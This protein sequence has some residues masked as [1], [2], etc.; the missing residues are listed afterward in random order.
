[1]IQRID[2]QVFTP[3]IKLESINLEKNEIKSITGDLFNGL[4]NLKEIHLA[5]NQMESFD[6]NDLLL[7]TL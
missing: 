6:L 2:S 1:M 4:V 5:Y 7:T 3:L